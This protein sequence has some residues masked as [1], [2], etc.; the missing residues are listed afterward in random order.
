[1]PCVALAKN[2]R[3]CRERWFLPR[4]VVSS[5][6]RPGKQLGFSA[7]FVVFL[8]LK[9]VLQSVLWLSLVCFVER[10]E[11]GDLGLGVNAPWVSCLYIYFAHVTPRTHRAAWP[12]CGLDGPPG[13]CL[14]YVSRIWFSTAAVSDIH[15]ILLTHALALFPPS[16]DDNKDACIFVLGFDFLT[17]RQL[18]RWS[19]QLNNWCAVP[20]GRYIFF[21]RQ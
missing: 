11:A 17:W 10:D 13:S 4:A 12:A 5:R 7:S 1:M 9:N 21:R 6:S 2:A 19:H 20:G 3:N 16:K 8:V 14:G 18:R 15:W